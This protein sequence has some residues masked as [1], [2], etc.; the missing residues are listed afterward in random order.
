MEDLAKV[1]ATT[2]ELKQYVSIT[3]IQ[4]K[5]LKRH[6]REANAPVPTERIEQHYD[7]EEITEEVV[8]A[9]KGS[10][11]KRLSLIDKQ[12]VKQIASAPNIIG[13]DVSKYIITK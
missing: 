12:S 13:F 1:Q 3:A 5:G 7:D 2:A 4:T 10:K 9:V 8:N 6:L 11:R